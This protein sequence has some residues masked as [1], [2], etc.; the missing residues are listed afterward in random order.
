MSP[1]FNI[2]IGVSQKS[3]FCPILSALYMV[4]LFHI[5]EKRTMNLFVPVSLLSFV[6]DSFSGEEL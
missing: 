6:N 1:L 5:F 2:D 4:P 3:A